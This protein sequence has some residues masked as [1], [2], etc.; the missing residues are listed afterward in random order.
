VGY[1]E[2][3]VMMTNGRKTNK[4]RRQVGG[5]GG[6]SRLGSHQSKVR[7]NGNPRLRSLLAAGVP[8][9]LGPG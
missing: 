9:G 8:H 5:A 1:K 3:W 4:A 6:N 7:K 2:K